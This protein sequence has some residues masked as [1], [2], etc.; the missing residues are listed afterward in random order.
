MVVRKE[1]RNRKYFGSRHWGL[2]NI[3]NGRGSG[4]RG[5]V[6]KG[7]VKPRWTWTTAKHPELIGKRG[8]HRWGQKESKWIDLYAI[9]NMLEKEKK[10]ILD[11]KG[12]KV[13]SRGE[14]NFKVKIKASG[15]SKKAME[16]IKAAES[17]AEVI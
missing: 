13:L 5:G 12:Y 10:E 11:L 8:F 3:K 14:L 16:K 6:G 7:A 1:K 15:F 2:G 17:T 9:N 4:D